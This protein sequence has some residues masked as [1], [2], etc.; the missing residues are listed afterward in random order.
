MEHRRSRVYWRWQGIIRVLGAVVDFDPGFPI[1][2]LEV[3]GPRTR[4]VT[5]QAICSAFITEGVGGAERRFQVI[6]RVV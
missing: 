5:F 1:A 2:S 6:E 4:G 3:D